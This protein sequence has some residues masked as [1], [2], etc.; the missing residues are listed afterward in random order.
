MSEELVIFR[1]RVEVTEEDLNG[2]QVNAQSAL[3]NVVRDTIEGGNK[4]AGLDVS[5]AT[6]TS[7]TV[8]NGRIYYGGKRY[9]NDASGGV[10]LNLNSVKPATQ[11]KYI[12]IVAVPKDQDTDLQERDVEI[13]ATTETYEPQNVAM[14][15]QRW[16]DVQAV[17]SLEAVSPVR[18]TPSNC[19]ILGYVLMTP[20]GI[21][22]KSIEQVEANR[23]PNLSDVKERVTVV[24]D[25]VEVVSAKTKTIADDIASL[26][27]QISG[28]T[29]LQM[30]ASLAA[31]VARLKAQASLPASYVNYR[32]NQF[33]DESQSDKAYSGYSAKISEG[34]RFADEAAAQNQL[35]LFN[36]Y[37]PL[38]KLSGGGLLLPSY[39][40]QIF[41]IIKGSAGRMPLAQYAYQNYGL[42]QATMGRQRT[43]FGAEFEAAANSSFFSGG[44][45]TGI[46][47]GYSAQTFVKAGETFQVY[48]TGQ[49]NPDGQKLYRVANYWVDTVSTPYW[50]RLVTTGN[51]QGYAWVQTWLQDQTGWCL[52]I[53]PKFSQKDG[54]A[55][56]TVGI[57]EVVNGL[58]DLTNILAQT[59][60]AAADV[61]IEA[62]LGTWVVPIEPTFL[63]AGKRYGYVII[64]GGNY[65]V[66]VA[67]IQQNA[68]GTCFYYLD[69]GV[70]YPSPTQNIMFDLAFASFTQ[71][72]TSINLGSLSLSGGIASID[73][74]AD[75]IVPAN[76]A[77]TYEVQVNG[78]WY[79]LS[80]VTASPLASLPPLLP[81]RATF[82]GTP[83]LMPGFRL[84]GSVCKVS[85][86]KTALKHG[87]KAATLQSSAQKITIKTTLID[88][89][90][91]HHTYT[92][93]VSAGGALKLAD[94]TTDV[95]IDSRTIE[96][97]QVFNLAAP[98]TAYVSELTGGTDSAA[99]LFH[100]AST[101][102]LAQ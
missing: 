97:T 95:V 9:F 84:N 4:Y 33:S 59:T 10:T 58:P 32:Q 45:L 41:R 40:T 92:G 86:P 29:G 74:L 83:N 39:K 70:P 56:V 37:D 13:D 23:V 75:T 34:L 11:A 7:V 26:A 96:R 67:D 35:Q 87:S 82:T 18:P 47:Q 48:D 76:T 93:K 101:F 5:F 61:V 55:S 17:A 21:T 6:T 52:G 78:V 88:F 54:A 16:A 30:I 64:T 12:A 85:R 77:L 63:Q 19:V 69:G 65:A 50:Q 3:D 36:P 80:E 60:I 24:E 20:A 99:R 27:G 72:Q 94:T 89:D 71:N 25:E 51:V 42:V 98:Q 14:A 22:E 31:D 66:N 15:R 28:L 102:E 53:T 38:A 62:P 46:A 81:L 91:L 90:P 1:D 43:R 73:I 8:S 57:C 44:V 100:V 49:V 2:A 68:G 79:P